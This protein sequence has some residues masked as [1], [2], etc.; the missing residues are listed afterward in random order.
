M[1]KCSGVNM[2]CQNNWAETMGADYSVT[3]APGKKL[4]VNFDTNKA[5]VR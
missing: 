1:A 2:I 3:T 5:E 4:Y